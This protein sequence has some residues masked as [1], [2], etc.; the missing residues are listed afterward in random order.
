MCIYKLINEE[1]ENI[2]FDRE[3]NSIQK[4]D[5]SFFV[6][7]Q[8]LKHSFKEFKFTSEKIKKRHY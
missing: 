4:K 5:F 7:D 6:S 1:L 2:I 3:R 8:Q